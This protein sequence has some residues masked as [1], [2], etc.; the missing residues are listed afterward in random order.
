MVC[1]VAW[2]VWNALNGIDELTLRLK[3]KK[4]ER[5][6]TKKFF[7]FPPLLVLLVVASCSKICYHLKDGVIINFPE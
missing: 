1:K 7:F 3:H 4:L 6:E 5:V 2:K